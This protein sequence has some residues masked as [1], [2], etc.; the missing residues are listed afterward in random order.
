MYDTMAPHAITLLANATHTNETHVY[1]VIVA[2]KPIIGSIHISAIIC[3]II[4]YFIVL[5]FTHDYI[6]SYKKFNT[7]VDSFDLFCLK[8][9]FPLIPSFIGWCIILFITDAILAIY[10]PEF[11]VIKSFASQ[12]DLLPL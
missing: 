7:N 4:V 8:Y 10:L 2:S 9:G 6:M 11:I 1:N 12:M 3:A 5:K